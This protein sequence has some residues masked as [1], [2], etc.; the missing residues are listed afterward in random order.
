MKKIIPFILSILIGC[1]PASEDGNVSKYQSGISAASTIHDPSLKPQK[2]L[3]VGFVAI[4][5]VYNSEL[6]APFDILQHTIFHTK[7]GM[8]TFIVSPSKDVITTFE[9]IRIIPD[10]SFDNAP[11]IDVLVVPSAEHNLDT[12]LEDERL[13]GFVKD[14]GKKASYV[15]SL[16][17]GAFVLAKAGLLD[18]LACTTFPSDIPLFKEK[19]PHLDV[20]ENVSF[21]HD[22]KVITSAGGAKSYDPALYL[23][24]LLYGNKVAKGVAGG[25][26][27]DWDLNNIAHEIPQ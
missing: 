18:N 17:D 27:I 2:V 12:D 19:F 6:M 4:N 21:V 9:G 3:N 24:E 23:V 10:Y 22:G 20:K 14:R 1:S 7:P 26:V 11:E 5:G 13:I 16:C 15:M 8:K 25:L